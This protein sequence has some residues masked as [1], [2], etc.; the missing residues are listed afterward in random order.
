MDTRLADAMTDAVCHAYTSGFLSFLEESKE[1]NRAGESVAIAGDLR[2]STD[3]IMAAVAQAIRDKG[4]NPIN[5]GRIPS[6]AVALFG[7]EQGMPA[8]M[9][10]GSHIPADRN[11]IK[12]NKCSGEILKQDE[13]RMMAQEVLYRSDVANLYRPRMIQRFLST[14]PA[15]RS[16]F[17][18]I[19]WRISK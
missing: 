18:R 12:F 13:A 16:Y 8:I 14:W 4:Y 1:L 15:I 9:V 3:R 5:C 19:V 17:L 7:L 11:G 2:P 6:P 10:T